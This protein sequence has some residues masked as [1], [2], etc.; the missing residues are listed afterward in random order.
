MINSEDFKGFRNRSFRD[1]I[2]VISKAVGLTSEEADS[3]VMD[4]P[5]KNP[6]TRMIEN[7]FTCIEYPVGLATNFVING[8]P[9]LIPMSLEEP[10][11]VAACSYAAKIASEKG[12]FRAQSSEPIMIGQIFLNGIVNRKQAAEKITSRKEEILRKANSFSDT[13]RKLGAGAKDILVREFNEEPEVLCVHLIVDVRDAMGANVVNSM[14]EG[15][16][17]LLEEI[18]GGKAF[19]KILSNLSSMRIAKASAVFSKEYIGGEEG[20]KRFLLS[21]RMAEIDPFRAATHNKG[22][23]NGIDSVLLATMNDWR[24]VEAG[25][26]SYPYLNGRYS[27]LTR[28]RVNEDGDVLGE[29]ELPLAVGTVGGAVNTVPKVKVIRKILGVSSAVEFSSVL[30]AVGLAQ[31]FAAVRALSMEGIQSGHMKL[32]SRNIAISAGAVGEEIDAV[33][34]EMIRDGKV[35][36]SHAAEI[37]EKIRSGT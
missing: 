26:H 23:M 32:H 16:A 3:L 36:V 21:C 10:S 14:A 6:V 2:D 28:Y 29:I 8:K 9:Y 34:A 30:A 12:G 18:S 35:S 13:L 33:S 4:N 19:M 11:V 1:R 27:S 22:I 15:T 5:E 20:V 7:V 17:P 37:L 24:A 31:N 25:A